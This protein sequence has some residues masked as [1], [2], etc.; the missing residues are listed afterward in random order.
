M[1]EY[2][3]PAKLADFFTLIAEHGA[4]EVEWL[5][6]YGDWQSAAD[7][8]PPVHGNIIIF[9]D[10]RL[11]AKKQYT[12]RA[13][14]PAPLRQHPIFESHYWIVSTLATLP[15]SILVWY[16]DNKD[17][18]MFERGLCFATPEDAEA[19]YRAMVDRSEE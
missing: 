10:C 5:D 19:N 4:K 17:L 13:E 2:H 16:G 7:G 11:R 14:V 12:V 15:V 8:T 18:M 1:I 3:S 6:K 9:S